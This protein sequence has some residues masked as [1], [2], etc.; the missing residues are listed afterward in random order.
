M[1]FQPDTSGKKFGPIWLTPG[2]SKFN[3]A[4]M[5]YGS[6]S[7]LMALSF[8]NFVQPYMLTEVYQIPQDQQ[9]ALTG[10]LQAVQEIIVILLMGFVGAYS[11]EVGRRILYSI[12][13]AIVG[14]GYF[15][16]PL[17]A[18]ELQLYIFRSVFAVG[19]AMVPVMLSSCIVDYVQNV[20]RGKWVGIGSVFNG[21]GVLVMSLVLSQTPK[22]YQAMGSDSVDA[23][24]YAFWTIAA[25]SMI[26]AVILQ[27]GLQGKTKNAAKSAEDNN[28]LERLSKGLKAGRNPKLALA[29]GAAFIGRGD[30]VIVA[31]FFSLWVVQVGVNNG[32]DS[33]DA[34]G[35]AGIMFGLVQLSALL[36]AFIMGVIVDKIDRVLA[37]SFGMTMATIGYGA[38]AFVPDP[39]SSS[40]I[41]F[42]IL[43]GIGETSVVIS[44]GALLGQEAPL[45]YRGAVVG[46]FGLLGGVG[47][48]FAS[49]VGGE[50]FDAISRTAPFVMMAIMNG[51]LALCA[52]Y[53]HVQDKAGRYPEF[54]VPSA[55]SNEPS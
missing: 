24:I 14:L 32:I 19:A 33:S 16:Y 21:L 3:A 39:Y 22:W 25:I 53:V 42:C 50:I 38:M 23:G 5:L 43:L 41:F 6:F 27:L 48:L 11:D 31:A 45:K 30:L 12:G 44:G 9:G 37:L 10:D 1:T 46:V 55:P 2:V 17:A 36:W 49:K 26:S 51:I 29:Y 35:R 18:D 20:S 4:T 13:F 28:L 8:M 47:I 52:L 34:Q 15:I 40:F 7:T 54:S